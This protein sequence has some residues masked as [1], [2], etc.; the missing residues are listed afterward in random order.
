MTIS[1]EERKEAF[2]SFFAIQLFLGP[3]RPVSVTCCYY[4]IMCFRLRNQMVES[5]YRIPFA[6]DDRCIHIKCSC[7]PFVVVISSQ[8]AF[9]VVVVVVEMFSLACFTY[10]S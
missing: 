10:F 6:S 5:I 2:F 8:A 1:G 3:P 4:I 7:S 9:V